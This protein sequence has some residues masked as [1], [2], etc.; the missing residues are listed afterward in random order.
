[1][2]DAAKVRTAANALIVNCGPRKGKSGAKVKPETRERLEQRGAETALIYAAAFY[3]GFRRG[4]L[5]E[6]RVTHLHL[7]DGPPHVT[8]P[9]ELTKNGKEASIP[10]PVAFARLLR[11]SVNDADPDSRVFR[12]QFM[13]HSDIRLTMEIY[14]DDQ[15]HDLSAEAVANLPALNL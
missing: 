1:L 7:D 5:H 13:R 2:R 14:N 6:L 15:L 10:L 4:E 9:G 3:T 12:V 11:Y 8:L